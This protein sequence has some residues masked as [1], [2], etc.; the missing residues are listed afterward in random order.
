MS[1]ICKEDSMAI[2]LLGNGLNQNEKLVCSWDEL[3]DST[4]EDEINGYDGT[5]SLQFDSHKGVKKLPS[6]EGLTM[7]LGFDLQEFYAIDHSI[8]DNTTDLKRKIADKMRQKMEK[9]TNEVGFQWEST[10][11]WAIMNLPISTYLTTNYDYSLEKS[12]D[13]TFKSKKGSNETI[14]SRYRKHIVN[15][16][17][18]SKTIYHIHGEL[19][20]P[21]SICLGFEQYSGSLEKMRS[22]L[23]R[24]TKNSED[25]TDDHRY[26]LSDVLMGLKKENGEDEDDGSWY[27][28]F[29]KED[30]YI[31]GL[32]L[33]FSEQDLWWLLDFR[34]R[35]IKYENNDFKIL[36]KI[37]FFDTDSTD[38]LSE[39]KY[40][41][42]NELLRAFGVEIIYLKGSEYPEKYKQ[43]VCLIENDLRRSK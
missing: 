33:D 18:E 6:V 15:I 7:T 22:D 9:I 39:G 24:S 36:N 5:K 42:R 34:I 43:A 14:Y 13:A 41:A 12:V 11:H 2:L 21:R 25:S 20:V 17:S 31:L 38:I 40:A 16:G 29:F 32:R 35:K 1:S 10:I 23:V 28:K 3:L 19:H 26:H 37:Y 8:A 4:F 30:V 27:I